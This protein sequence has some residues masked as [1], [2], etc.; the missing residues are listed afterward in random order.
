MPFPTS[1]PVNAIPTVIGYLRNTGVSRRAAAEA[2]Y[3][4]L[5]YGGNLALPEDGVML[6]SSDEE[7]GN[8][9]AYAG[10][11][12]AS[13]LEELQADMDANPNAA[14]NLPQWLV[15]LLLEVLRRILTS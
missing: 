4:L 14:F 2:A 6:L 10:D 11:V 9:D 1:F 15:P 3:D 8:I 13:K 12:L 5:G 7:L